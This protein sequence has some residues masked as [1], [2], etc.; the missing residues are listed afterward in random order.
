MCSGGVEYF[1]IPALLLVSGIVCLCT[2]LFLYHLLE[3]SYYAA[4]LPSFLSIL[5][6]TWGALFGVLYLTRHQFNLIYQY[7]PVLV[8]TVGERY[9]IG[10]RVKM[11]R[12]GA[13]VWCQV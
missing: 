13:H 5:L 9:L 6:V 11:Y 3:V 4:Q 8:W 2:T 10:S 12:F 1:T 7:T